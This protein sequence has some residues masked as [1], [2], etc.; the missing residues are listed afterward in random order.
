M[1]K[2]SKARNSK[3]VK[4]EAKASQGEAELKGWQQISSFLGEPVSVVQRWAGE[5]MP[6]QREGRFVSITPAKLNAWLGRESGKPIHVVTESSDLSAELKRGLTFVRNEK[7]SAG[8][9]SLK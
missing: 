6:V 8:K 9:R 5:G 3:A 7:R 4:S 2:V 1:A